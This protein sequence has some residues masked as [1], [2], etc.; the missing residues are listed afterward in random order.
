MPAVSPFSAG[1]KVSTPYGKGFVD[2]VRADGIIKIT[3]CDWELAQKCKPIF[4]ANEKD[5]RF[6][7]GAR[8]TTPYGVAIVDSYRETDKMY[9]V[10]PESWRLANDCKPI[11][12]MQAEYMK[13]S[14]LYVPNGR[15]QK[16]V[17]EIIADAEKLKGEGAI[18][19]QAG[20]FVA[21]ISKYQSCLTLIDSGRE[22]S[23]EERAQIFELTVPCYNNIA[24]CLFKQ[25]DKVAIV[26]CCDFAQTALRL[27]QA[28]ENKIERGQSDFGD[29]LLARGVIKSVD[30]LRKTWS[31]KSRTLLGDA[32]M[33][34]SDHNQAI[35]HYNGAI[36][37]LNGDPSFESI[38]KGLND[39]IKKCK[40][41]QKVEKN[42]EK[43]FSQRIFNKMGKED[44]DAPATTPSSSPPPSPLRIA[45]T[46][47]SLYSQ[48]PS[49][50]EVSKAN[51]AAEIK[52]GKGVSLVTDDDDEVDDDEEE[53]EEVKEGIDKSAVEEE[54]A[55]EELSATDWTVL[56]ISVV[57]AIAGGAYLFL[58]GRR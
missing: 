26:S 56:G 42:K 9:K 17:P 31:R 54:E 15:Q 1:I 7:A 4:Y 30:N 36:A 13:A 37:C 11:F 41:L 3:A 14:P 10:I 19:F 50:P 16:S 5:V 12:Y 6:A 43:K 55:E 33:L 51:L 8:V 25:K 39:K 23:N 48:K 57:A 32:F 21:A 53:E 44:E 38:I 29:A 58:K 52:K 46:R 40:Q 45:E 18:F 27:C 34:R 47:N 24:M 49:S 28:V 22:M 2:E 20:D 35:E